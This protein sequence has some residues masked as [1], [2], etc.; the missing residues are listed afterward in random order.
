M[1]QWMAAVRAPHSTTTGHLI[2]SPPPLCMCLDLF[3]LP[4]PVPGLLPPG[5]GAEIWNL[6]HLAKQDPHSSFSPG[7]NASFLSRDIRRLTASNTHHPI[8]THTFLPATTWEREYHRQPSRRPSRRKRKKYLGALPA[9]GVQTRGRQAGKRLSH[10]IPS[11]DGDMSIP[12]LFTACWSAGKE[13][14]RSREKNMCGGGG[15]SG[16]T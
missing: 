4:L 15:V 3:S 10:R 14:K 16:T 12:F 8:T 1:K 11:L 13:G 5:R 6:M 7:M 9:D 2:L